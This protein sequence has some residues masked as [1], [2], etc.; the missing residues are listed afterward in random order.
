MLLFLIRHSHDKKFAKWKLLKPLWDAL[1]TLQLIFFIL[2]YPIKSKK[3]MLSGIL[4][5]G[6]I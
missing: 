2:V 4:A 6:M 1:F 3:W 5:S